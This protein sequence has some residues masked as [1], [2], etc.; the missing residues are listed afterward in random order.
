MGCGCGSG[1]RHGRRPTVGPRQA[2]R[3]PRV[4]PRKTQLA[5][6]AA[7]KNVSAREVVEKKRKN[8]IAKRL[9]KK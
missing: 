3:Q 4:P 1:R 2:A 6:L 8:A 5:A 9:N 7:Q